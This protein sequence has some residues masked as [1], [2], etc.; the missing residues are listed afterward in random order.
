M[1]WNLPAGT[2]MC[3]CMMHNTGRRQLSHS[4]SQPKEAFCNST[5]LQ[6]LKYTLFEV[7]GATALK[8][9]HVLL[10]SNEGQALVP[11]MQT[12]KYILVSC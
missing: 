9:Q 12:T 4:A 8:S 6:H 10:F 3:I 2:S 1:R 7:G 5:C 11:Y